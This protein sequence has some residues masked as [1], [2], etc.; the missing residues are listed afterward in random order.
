MSIFNKIKTALKQAI[1]YEKSQEK[2]P[3]I[4]KTDK[5][6]KKELE[7]RYL[8]KTIKITKLEDPYA[9]YVGR[10]GIVTF[11]DDIGQLHGTWGGLAII[12]DLD[13]FE[14]IE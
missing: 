12:P 2:N 11:V 13:E 8:R 14:V 7:G 6:T 4:T 1:S 3:K 5:L 10:R 9:D